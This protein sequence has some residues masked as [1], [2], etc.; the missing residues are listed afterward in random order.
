MN[1]RLS[2]MA[3]AAKVA[4]ALWRGRCIPTDMTGKNGGLRHPRVVKLGRIGLE[5]C[6]SCVG[7]QG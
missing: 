5:A 6:V 3:A 1:S 7:G 2:K 4:H